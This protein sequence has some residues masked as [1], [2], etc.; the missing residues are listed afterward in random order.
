[1]K[2][3]MTIK[4]VRF[5]ETEYEIDTALTMKNQLL[6]TLLQLSGMIRYEFIRNWRRKGL[7]MMMII[8]LVAVIWGTTIFSGPDFFQPGAA[9]LEGS[10][11]VRKTEAT[12]NI[13]IASGGISSVFA[14]FT[15][16]IL[17]AEI[18]PLDRQLGVME[19]FDTLPLGPASYLVGK[20]LG[21]WAAIF[22]GVLAISIL[23][24]IAHY[25]LIGP[26]DLIA[27]ARL[28]LGAL[29]LTSLY[30]SGLSALVTS[31]LRSRRW[32]VFVGMGLAIVS[33]IYLIPSILQLMADTYMDFFIKN[34]ALLQAEACRIQPESCGQVFTPPTFF[35]EI[36]NN[37]LHR[38]WLLV[39][40]FLVTAVSAW[41]WRVKT[42]RG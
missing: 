27:F 3:E 13:L 20:I 18:V 29:M 28:W 17:A 4:V 5:F 14:I 25:L 24:G 10:A 32:A 21:L 38:V 23:S 6:R 15:L 12:V 42:E 8:W 34:I 26:F 40:V 33:Y 39:G 2:T 19:W 37:P 11:L 22:S 7:P 35:P 16:S 36:I 31:W 30:I 1:M 41:A 9:I